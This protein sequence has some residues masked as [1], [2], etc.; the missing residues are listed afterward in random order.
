[1][2]YQGIRFSE[3]HDILEKN[4]QGSN[5]AKTDEVSTDNLI[6]AE[7]NVKKID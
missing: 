1:M 6:N 5:Q 2:T 3:F 7:T 4:Y